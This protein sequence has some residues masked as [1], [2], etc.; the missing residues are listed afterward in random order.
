MVINMTKRKTVRAGYW[1]LRTSRDT[2]TREL[3]EHTKERFT[4]QG[5]KASIRKTPYGYRI[6]GVMEGAKKRKLRKID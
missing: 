1:A 6:T 5:Y 3:A 4:K 2:E